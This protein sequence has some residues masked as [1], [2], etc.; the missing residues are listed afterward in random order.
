MQQ[1]NIEEIRKHILK[2]YNLKFG[3]KIKYDLLNT[4]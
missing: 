2:K 4:I 1:N 3:D